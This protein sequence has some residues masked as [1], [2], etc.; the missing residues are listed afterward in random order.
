ML[1][2][3]QI[4]LKPNL[5]QP[6]VTEPQIMALPTRTYRT[7]YRKAETLSAGRIS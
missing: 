7:H 3:G 5:S 6:T 4:F 1:D 2:V